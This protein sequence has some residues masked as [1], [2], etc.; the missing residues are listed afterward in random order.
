MEVSSGRS[1]EQ[2]QAAARPS[3]CCCA[4]RPPR[5]HRCAAA[6]GGLL[7]AERRNPPDCQ[8][9]SAPSPRPGRAH[10]SL[11][12][13]RE[14]RHC[15]PVPGRA[16]ETK[17]F[18]A[19]GQ[20]KAGATPLARKKQTTHS[21]LGLCGFFESLGATP[22]LAR[23]CGA[24][25]G[26]IPASLGG[27]VWQRGRPLPFNSSE[28]L[29]ANQHGCWARK[30]TPHKSAALRL[31]HSSLGLWPEDAQT[32]PPASLRFVVAGS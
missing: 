27:V 18:G 6:A 22:R 8:A 14:D 23:A 10:Q 25:S 15:S 1:R 9:R 11:S 26:K 31:R 24:V 5:P 3:P 21:A 30:P 12:A 17:A 20:G 4:R 2:P 28:R 7:W 32:L 13:C 16:L 29:A 19:P